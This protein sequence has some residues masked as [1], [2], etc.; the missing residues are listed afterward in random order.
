MGLVNTVDAHIEMLAKS[1]GCFPAFKDF[2]LDILPATSLRLISSRRKM[3]VCLEGDSTERVSLCESL[4]LHNATS[5][6]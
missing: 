6:N 1:Y 3:L 5:D 2:P 4:P